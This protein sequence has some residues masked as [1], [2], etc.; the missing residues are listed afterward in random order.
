MQKHVMLERQCKA[1]QYNTRSSTR[2][3]HVN[4]NDTPLEPSAAIEIKRE[5]DEAGPLDD[6]EPSYATAEPFTEPTTTT[7]STTGPSDA[8][9]PNMPVEKEEAM[10][11][12]EPMDP[13]EHIRS[14]GGQSKQQTFEEEWRELGFVDASLKTA[15]L[16]S[17][18]DVWKYFLVNEVTGKAICKACQLEFT[19]KDKFACGPRSSRWTMGGTMSGHIRKKR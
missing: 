17:N 9:V 11:V 12:D 2:T 13:N 1:D 15:S 14:Q 7:E 16:R 4:V 3:P 5:V 18:S 6:E 8:T 19:M 10:E